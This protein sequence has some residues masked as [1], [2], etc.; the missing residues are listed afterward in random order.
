M[1]PIQSLFQ[2]QAIK[3]N[4]VS[5]YIYKNAI[6][7]FVQYQLISHSYYLNILLFKLYNQY[8]DYMPG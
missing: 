2:Y 6:L 5:V 3:K 4:V 8:K 1:N 7:S